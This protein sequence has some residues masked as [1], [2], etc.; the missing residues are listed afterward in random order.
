MAD[1][2]YTQVVQDA[3]EKLLRFLQT[4]ESI[5][6]NTH[7]GNLEDSQA[8]LQEVVGD[9]FSTLLSEL[10]QLSPPESLSRFH[11]AFAAAVRHCRN[12]SEAFLKPAGTD[13]SVAS[14]NSRRALC[15][16]MNLLYDIRAYLPTL[17]SYW[18]LPEAMPNRDALETTSPDADAP[19]GVI[20]NRRTDA[21]DYSLY[22]PENYTPRKNW[23]LIICLHG[24]NGRGDH[25]IWSWLRAAKS[26]GYLLLSPKSVD[27]TWSVLR[28]LEDVTSIT[29]MFQEVCATYAVDKSRVYLSGLSDG[30]TFTYLFGLSSAEMFTGIA[31]V[32][33]DFH[34][35]M[36]GMLRLKQGIDLPIYIVHGVH[37]FIFNVDSIR[38][39]HELLTR[40][41]YNATY[42]ELP[43]WGHAYCS[44]IN[45]QLVLPW[46]E[47]LPPKAEAANSDDANSEA[48]NSDDE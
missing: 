23:P 14:L 47:S 40:L 33:G 36:D 4:F 24:A 1:E 37:D 35:M 48:A 6:E 34:P 11:P 9:V 17:Q 3:E 27:V 25:Y 5:Q 18:L 8:R 30:G 10:E 12:A 22:V 39:G 7:I 42:K 46:F 32:A 26:K 13:F 29:D 16:A 28:P 44:S 20:H 2:Q 15:R 41:G 38:T 45:Q 21:A 43:D 31:P 19:V